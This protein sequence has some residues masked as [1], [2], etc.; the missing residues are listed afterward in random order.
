[1]DFNCSST[2]PLDKVL[3]AQTVVDTTFN[4]HHPLEVLLPWSPLTDAK[5]PITYQTLD[6]FQNKTARPMPLMLGAT[7]EDALMFVYMADAS[8][9]NAIE[10]VGVVS[11][12]F[13]TG[14]PWVLKHY[15]PNGIRDMRPL[16]STLLTDYVMV[17]SSR[18]IANLAASYFPS[19]APVY[20]YQFNHPLS[21]DGWGPNYTFCV[22][23]V[24]HGADLPF[25]F[26]R[27]HSWLHF[28][29]LTIS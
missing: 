13:T 11:F 21:F 27:S 9:V 4:Y 16:L 17:C 5:G 15:P 23:K 3:D 12:F 7:S 19:N 22:D 20:Y 8:P 29:M 25:V 14:A 26:V 24:C 6:A 28:V 10:Y 1:M 18:H 2:A